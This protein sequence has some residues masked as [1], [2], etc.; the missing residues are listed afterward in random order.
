MHTSFGRGVNEHVECIIERFE[1]RHRSDVPVYECYALG[2]QPFQVPFGS[3]A[4]K[5]V[6]YY[7]RRARAM[8]PKIFCQ[9]AAHEP[10]TTSDQDIHP[11][12]E[13]LL[14]SRSKLFIWRYR[15]QPECTQ[16]FA[17][18]GLAESA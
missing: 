7:D 8:A 14:A 10:S 9:R 12:S 17:A 16:W 15:V 3:S 2:A 11:T 13:E 4:V 1:I 18:K 6:N 5:V